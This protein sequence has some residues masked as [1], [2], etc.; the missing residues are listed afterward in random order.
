MSIP[1]TDEIVSI[2]FNLKD[3]GQEFSPQEVWIMLECSENPKTIGQ[4]AT[5]AD[6]SYQAIS[7]YVRSLKDKKMLTWLEVAKESYYRCPYD[8]R[9][10]NTTTISILIKARRVTFEDLIGYLN[11]NFLEMIQSFVKQ[12]VSHTYFRLMKASQGEKLPDPSP[13]DTKLFLKA[14][15]DEL[16]QYAALVNQITELDIYDDHPRTLERLTE[17]F[18]HEHTQ[19]II[20]WYNS[21]FQRSWDEKNFTRKGLGANEYFEVKNLIATGL[22]KTPWPK[23]SSEE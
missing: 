5:K 15:Q 21:L 16:L 12:A 2:A 23:N 4:L 10:E 1:V 17:P 20:E 18:K 8:I 22:N 11:L 14:M 19:G 3:Q 9:N 13:V 6:V 7:K